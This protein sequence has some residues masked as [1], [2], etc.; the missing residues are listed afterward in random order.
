M[1]SC[2]GCALQPCGVLVHPL[3]WW[4][5]RELA[6]TAEHACDEIAARVVAQPR[7][8]AE[9]LVDMADAVRRHRGRVAWQ[10][11]GVDGAGSLEGRI[12]RVLEGR[13][14]QT[15]RA[16]TLTALSITAGAILVVVAC[17]QQVPELK[18]DPRSPNS[19]RKKTRG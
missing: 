8:Y 17:R 19:S 12:D 16:R 3:A 10:A 1:R 9:I 7:R 5:E 11:V 15:S 6:I 2:T 13:F 4:L 14:A 18:Q